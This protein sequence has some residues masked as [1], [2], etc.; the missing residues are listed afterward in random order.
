MTL[1]PYIHYI[2]F[3][4]VR[5]LGPWFVLV[6]GVVHIPVNQTHNE[7][8]RLLRWPIEDT[9]LT[10]LYRAINFKGTV[11]QLCTMPGMIA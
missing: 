5:T 3:S 1:M 9:L 6:S 2:E 8:M 10:F 11:T 4:R 7:D